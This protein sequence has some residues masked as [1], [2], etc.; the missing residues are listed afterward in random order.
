M[1]VSTNITNMIKLS[2]LHE[3]SSRLPCWNLSLGYFPLCQIGT[4]H[5]IWWRDIL[6]LPSSLLCAFLAVALIHR[7]R[8]ICELTPSIVSWPP[9]REGVSTGMIVKQIG[10]AAK[11]LSRYCVRAG[12]PFVC[13]LMRN[14][15]LVIVV[16]VDVWLQ[17]WEYERGWRCINAS[18]VRVREFNAAT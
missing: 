5:L 2:G 12:N 15:V 6:A 4:I 1:I 11:L 9:D 18:C 14:C 3:I 16:N 17:V 13:G 7:Q 10:G 8:H